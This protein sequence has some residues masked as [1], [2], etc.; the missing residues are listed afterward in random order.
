MNREKTLL[1]LWII[2]G[3]V[4]VQAVDSVLFFLTQLVYFGTISIGIS[5]SI[6][7][8][9]LPV[10]T[11]ALYL[12]TILFLLKKIKNT[13]STSGILLTEFP[14]KQ[15][16]ILTILA[17]VLNPL[18][19]KLS[20]LFAEYFSYLQNE[21]ISGYLEFYGWM[22][23]GIGIARWSSIVLLAMIFLRKHNTV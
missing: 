1:I 19:H 4:F 22:H 3:F 8:Y 2:Y 23:M 15:F 5:Y 17:I 13:S 11:I 20:G 14:K 16:L 10:V 18:T 6:L 9:L 21:D 12:T 7:N